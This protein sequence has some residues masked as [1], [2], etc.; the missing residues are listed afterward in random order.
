MIYGKHPTLLNVHYIRPDKKNGVEECFEVIY[1]DDEGVPRVSYEPALVDIYF[2]K[3]KYR[4]FDYNK[5]QERIE[6]LNKVECLLSEVRYKIAEEIGEEGLNFIRQCFQNRDYKAMDRLYGW[7]YAFLCDFDPEFYFMKRWYTKYPMGSY[8]LTKAFLD[9]EIDLMDYQVNLDNLKQT[10]FAP[11]NCT[12]VILDETNE[13]FTFILKPQKPPKLSYTEEEYKER[14]KLYEKQLKDHEWLESHK[15]EFIKDLHDS[16]DGMYGVLTYNLRI[17][18]KDI[19]LIADMFRLINDRKPN[20][21]VAWNM[22]FD[23]QYLMERSKVLGYNPASIMCHPDFKYPMCYYHADT[24]SFEIKKQA[25]YFYCSSYTTYMCQMRNFSMVRKSQK[26]L[27]SV[28]LNAISDKILKDKKVEYPAESNIRT[29]PYEDWIR[30]IKY[31][32]KDSL[33]QLGIERKTKD[34]ET[35]YFRSHSNWTPYTKIFKETYLI[36]NVREIYF[37]REGYVQQNNINIINNDEQDLFNTIPDEDD[38]DGAK[39]SS[40]KG[41]INAD[42]EWNDYVGLPVLGSPSNN[43]FHNMIDFDMGSFYPSIKIASNMDPSTLLYKASFDNN[44]F[45][46]G[47]FPNRSLNVK[48]KETNKFGDIVNLD[49]T[50][51][52]VNTYMGG[53][54]LSFGYEYLGLPSITELERDLEKEMKK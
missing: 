54:I 24:R 23:Y 39:E 17:Y 25:D 44:E 13:V 16:F 51:E 21:C 26:T 6:R 10:A 34:I 43:I 30:F 4:D 2:V 3:P 52:A 15:D 8:K 36:R 22:R 1:K 37:E 50:G 27:D 48:Y 47:Q 41:A 20:F 38:E 14:Y 46:S 28:K 12:T 35:I 49:I 45:E 9:I 29:F 11:V 32:I 7:R 31:N 19:D 40:F 18:E 33:L 53:N 5:P 42:P